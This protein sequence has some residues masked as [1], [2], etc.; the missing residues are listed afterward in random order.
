MFV[1]SAGPKGKEN[2]GGGWVP[3]ANCKGP[4]I[5]VAGKEDRTGAS[6]ND[7]IAKWQAE[8][9]KQAGAA[10]SNWGRAGMRDMSCQPRGGNGMN[11]RSV[12]T[13]TAL[14]CP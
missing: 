10:Y 12:C 2:P 13:A 9:S 3:F 8:A 5:S 14:P 6:M 11:R 4:K 1:A 7:A